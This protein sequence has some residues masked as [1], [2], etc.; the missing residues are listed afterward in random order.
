MSKDPVHQAV[1]DIEWLR[2]NGVRCEWREEEYFGEERVREHL[3]I[4]LSPTQPVR[5]LRLWSIMGDRA[6]RLRKL[7]ETEAGRAILRRAFV[8]ADKKG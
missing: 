5:A 8:I 7:D 4:I 6:T 3:V 2:D 1:E